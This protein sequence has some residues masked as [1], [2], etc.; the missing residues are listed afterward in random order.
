MSKYYVVSG[1]ILPDVLEQVMQARILLLF[2][3]F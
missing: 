1:D 3:N 2:G